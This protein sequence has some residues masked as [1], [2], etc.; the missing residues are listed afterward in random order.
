MCSES[1][2]ELGR[3]RDALAFS[4]HRVSLTKKMAAPFSLDMLKAACLCHGLSDD[5]TAEELTASLGMHLVTELL[6]P[7]KKNKKRKTTRG[8]GGWYAFMKSEKANVLAS[9]FTS[10]ADVL[11][12]LARRWKLAKLVGTSA[13]PLALPPP[14][15]SST[16]AEPAVASDSEDADGLVDALK[17]L[18]EAELNAAMAAHSMPVNG[19]HE[20]KARALARVMMA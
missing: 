4:V 7:D 11:K 13:Q 20:E 10:R 16:D 5:G 12:E 19:D 2:R 8:A 14:S 1:K 9:G 6:S 18:D 15:Q 17:E 3:G